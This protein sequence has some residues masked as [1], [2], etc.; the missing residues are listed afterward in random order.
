MF[1]NLFLSG[2]VAGYRQVRAA[3][4]TLPE[5]WRFVV[6]RAYAQKREGRGGIVFSHENVNVHRPAERAVCLGQYPRLGGILSRRA[7]QK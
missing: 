4:R 1:I 3:R 2:L 6:L 5:K 7:C